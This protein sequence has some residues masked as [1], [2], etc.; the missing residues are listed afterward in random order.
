V[1]PSNSWTARRFPV[2]RYMIVTFVRLSV[3][4]FSG[5]R[6]MPAVR[7]PTRRAYCRVVRLRG[8]PRRL[9]NKNCPGRLPVSFK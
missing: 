2:R 9:V 1:W 8:S 6:P 3:P 4:N 7:S 5:S